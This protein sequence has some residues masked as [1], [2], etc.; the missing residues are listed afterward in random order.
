[1]ARI[2]NGPGG[3]STGIRRTAADEEEDIEKLVENFKGEAFRDWPNEAG[4][5]AS[6]AWL[7]STTEGHGELRIWQERK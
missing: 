1:M 4:V 3:P 6:R 7:G 2:L 5:S